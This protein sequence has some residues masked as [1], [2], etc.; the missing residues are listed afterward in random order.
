[1]ERQDQSCN[2]TAK[3]LHSHIIIL[4]VA[5]Y[6][7]RVDVLPLLLLNS[8]SNIVHMGLTIFFWRKKRSTSCRT[9]DHLSTD[10]DE[11]F[12]R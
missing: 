8:E 10:S 2:C 6:V 9:K 3:W 1:M 4:L 12:L 7:A 11:A 5:L